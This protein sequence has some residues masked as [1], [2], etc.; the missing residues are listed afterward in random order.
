MRLA[1]FWYIDSTGRPREKVEV[2]NA[3]NFRYALVDL[4][5]VVP[6]NTYQN[7]QQLYKE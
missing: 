3:T 6:A 1:G 2:I 4:E 7:D 5:K